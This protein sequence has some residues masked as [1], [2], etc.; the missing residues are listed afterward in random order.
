MEA[1]KPGPDGV[2]LAEMVKQGSDLSKLHNIDFELRF[3][4]QK[5]ADRADLQLLE[6]AFAVEIS[7][8]KDD[9]DWVVK[10]SKHM[11]P[12]ESDLMGLRDKLNVI[13]AGGHGTYVGWK[14]KAIEQKK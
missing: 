10:A 1:Q 7:H 13:A 2:A 8:G 14:A 3:P 9:S 6:L 11:Y 5:A 12:I 4:T